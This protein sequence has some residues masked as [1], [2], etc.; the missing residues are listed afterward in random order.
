QLINKDKNRKMPTGIFYNYP[1]VSD[2]SES[3]KVI[4]AYLKSLIL[5]SG[6]RLAIKLNGSL[7]N[8]QIK[9]LLQISFVRGFSNKIH[10]KYS[11]H[12]LKEI[13][14]IWK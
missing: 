14:R 6:S 5:G 10:K 1:L 12:R 11:L 13:T 4:D 9:T 3:L 8:R 7:S 2:D